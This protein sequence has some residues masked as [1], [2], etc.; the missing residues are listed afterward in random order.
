MILHAITGRKSFE[1][2]ARR[3]AGYEDSATARLRAYAGKAVFTAR[4]R[5]APPPKLCGTST[6]ASA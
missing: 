4:R 5:L 6:S 3:W 1:A 2:F